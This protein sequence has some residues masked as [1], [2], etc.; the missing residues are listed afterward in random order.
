MKKLI[1]LFILFSGCATP[2]SDYIQGCYDGINDYT[3]TLFHTVF[4]EESLKE[5]CKQLE[6]KNSPITREPRER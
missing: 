6:N 1:L 5:H 2:Q 4:D 3:I